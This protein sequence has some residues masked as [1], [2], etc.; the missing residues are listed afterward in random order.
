MPKIED[1]LFHLRNK[2]GMVRVKSGKSVRTENICILK[3]IYND[4]F[5]P[6]LQKVIGKI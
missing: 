4:T 5:L 6:N 1:G 2:F 3:C